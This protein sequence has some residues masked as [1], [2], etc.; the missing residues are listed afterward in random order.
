MRKLCSS[1]R[2]NRCWFHND[3][4]GLAL[5]SVLVSRAGCYYRPPFHSWLGTD[6]H[7]NLPWMSCI[8]KFR[9]LKISLETLERSFHRAEKTETSREASWDIWNSPLWLPN[10]KMLFQ[11]EQSKFFKTELFSCLPKVDHVIKSCKEPSDSYFTQFNTKTKQ[12][13]LIPKVTCHVDKNV[14]QR[15]KPTSLFYLYVL[16][17]D[18]HEMRQIIHESRTSHKKHH[19]SRA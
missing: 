5:T 14:T 3:L 6:H 7:W 19:A 8:L 10:F 13:E 16:Y 1:W 11:P 12:H 9:S 2:F 4:L 18:F 15:M 17:H